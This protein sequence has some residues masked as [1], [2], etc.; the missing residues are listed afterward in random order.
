[1]SLSTLRFMM[2]KMHTAH[3]KLSWLA[4]LSTAIFL[5]IVCLYSSSAV[6]QP[7]QAM[8][9]FLFATA[10]CFEQSGAPY[11]IP[12][13]TFD[14]IVYSMSVSDQDATQLIEVEVPPCEEDDLEAKSCQEP[15]ASDKTRVIPAAEHSTWWSA[16]AQPKPPQRQDGPSCM[17][18]DGASCES[19]PPL[20]TLLEIK[21]SVASGYLSTLV[22][23]HTMWRRSGKLRVYHAPVVAT[24]TLGPAT[25]ALHPPT[26]PPR[27]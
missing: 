10:H 6:A 4:R 14:P 15:M 13:T 18:A 5:A 19:S 11:S 27:A 17:S 21:G 8:E 23:A 3:A 26:P 7:K 2:E 22:R 25:L 24:R 16:T 20:P 9:R 12:A 1:M